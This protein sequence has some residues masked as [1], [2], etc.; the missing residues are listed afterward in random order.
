MFWDS[1]GKERIALLDE[2]RRPRILI[3]LAYMMHDLTVVANRM[4]R[5]K[6]RKSY[7]EFL[8]RDTEAAQQASYKLRLH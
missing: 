4:L 2:G 6:N 8:K 5:A 3:S 1:S 7:L